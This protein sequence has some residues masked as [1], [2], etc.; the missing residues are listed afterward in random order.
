[1]WLEGFKVTRKRWDDGVARVKELHEPGELVTF[2]AY[3]W[4]STK[5]GDYHIVFPYAEAPL[6]LP[7]TLEKLQELV[8]NSDAI[9][10]P[11]HPANRQGMRGANFEMRDPDVAPLMEVY[12]EWGNAVSDRGPYPYIRHS[13][14]GR[15][16]RNTLRYR[17]SKGDRLG[18][19]ASTDNHFGKPGRITRASPPSSRRTTRGR[20]SSTRCGAGG[21]T[22]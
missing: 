18:V 1:M 21:A 20:A 13:H 6:V 19:I 12:S 7:D 4:H 17:L 9:M 11:H 2:P 15:W 5:L 10:I 14:G 3:E 16:T 8:R 22:R